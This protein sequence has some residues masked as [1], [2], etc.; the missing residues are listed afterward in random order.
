MA[1]KVRVVPHVGCLQ[2]EGCWTTTE[3]LA[4]L[5]GVSL[6]ASDSDQGSQIDAHEEAV[7]DLERMQSLM[8]CRAESMES[9]GLIGPGFL[10]PFDGWF[11]RLD[12]SWHLVAT[13]RNRHRQSR[14]SSGR[15]NR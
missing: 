9:W 8:E 4:L 1:L 2:L 3:L 6:E 13:A 7:I 11:A 5:A 12:V 10:G 15:R 14:S